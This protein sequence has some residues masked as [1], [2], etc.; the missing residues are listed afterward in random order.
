MSTPLDRRQFL[1]ILGSGTA[2]ALLSPLTTSCAS[3]ASPAAPEGDGTASTTGDE[4]PPALRIPRS[5]PDDWDP[6]AFNRDRGHAGA[7]PESYWPSIDAADGVPNALGKHLPYVP[8]IE[9]FTVTAGTIAI[10]WG[11]TSKGYAKHPNAVRNETNQ[12]HGHWYDWIE[13]RK[14]TEGEAITQRSDYPE[15]PGGEGYAVLG[16]GDITADAGKNTVYLAALPS[17][18]RPGDLVRIHANCLTHGEYVDFL[19]VPG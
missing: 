15:W 3:T 10:M 14:A 2:V 19:V 9:G 8:A 18:V 4:L 13:I 11:D 5:K 6:I 12:N 17:D 1:R 16:G 7:I